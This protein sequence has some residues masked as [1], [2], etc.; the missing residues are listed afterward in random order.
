MRSCTVRPGAFSRWLLAAAWAKVTFGATA[1]RTA[2]Q[3]VATMTCRT[4]GK[5]CL[6]TDAVEGHTIN[7]QP[8]LSDRMGCSS[9]AVVTG[10]RTITVEPAGRVTLRTNGRT[11]GKVN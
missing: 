4:A 6:C 5:I 7:I 1:T 10:R 8:G 3:E 9:M 2:S 11:I